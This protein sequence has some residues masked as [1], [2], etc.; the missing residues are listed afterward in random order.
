MFLVEHHG[1]GSVN[2]FY[3][4]LIK[5]NS[6]TV[7]GGTG[8]NYGGSGGDGTVTVGNISSGTFVQE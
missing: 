8:A 4:E 5:N 2:I 1:G 6:V 7:T 3:N